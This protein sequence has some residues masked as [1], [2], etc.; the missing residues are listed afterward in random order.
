MA[1][2][3]GVVLNI[4]GSCYTILGTPYASRVGGYVVNGCGVVPPKE[5]NDEIILTNQIKLLRIHPI[6][7]VLRVEISNRT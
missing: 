1:D 6:S 3:C 2:R 5:C 7:L 4:I